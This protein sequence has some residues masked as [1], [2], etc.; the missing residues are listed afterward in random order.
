MTTNLQRFTSSY[1]SECAFPHVTV[2]LRH[3]SQVVQRY[4]GSVA[5]PAQ[6]VFG[7]QKFGGPKCLILGEQQYFLWGTASQSAK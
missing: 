4:S 5:Q 7:G 6:Y 2:D 1:D 3:L